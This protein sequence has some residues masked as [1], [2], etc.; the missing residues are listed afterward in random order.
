MFDQVQDFKYM[1]DE[2]TLLFSAVKEGQ[3]D[4]FVYKIDARN[5]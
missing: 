3:S 4:I 2:N 1:L 5:N